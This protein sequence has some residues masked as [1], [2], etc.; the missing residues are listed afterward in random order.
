LE[1][2]ADR[3]AVGAVAAMWGNLKGGMAKIGQNALPQLK[4]GLRL[5]RCAGPARNIPVPTTPVPAT[6]VQPELTP[7]QRFEQRKITARDLA[8]AAITSRLC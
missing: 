8:N 5:Q 4:S 1:E 3:S 7:E 2:D 6:P